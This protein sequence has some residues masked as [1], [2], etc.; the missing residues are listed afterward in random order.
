MCISPI[1]ILNKNYRSDSHRL[2]AGDI[3]N[4]KDTTSQ[5]ILVPCGHCPD[6]VRARQ[7]AI[8]QRTTL[9]SLG[10]HMFFAT[11]TYNNEHLP[12]AQNPF[13]PEESYAYADI[14]HLQ[15][16]M[17][18]LRNHGYVFRYL[19]CSERGTKRGR[20]HFHVLFFFDKNLY[21]DPYSLERRLFNDVLKLWAKNVGTRKD[22]KYIPLCTYTV[23]RNGR[24]NYD[25]HYCVPSPVNGYD[26]VAFYVS[27]Y[28][29]KFA[30]SD[31]KLK[32][33]IWNSLHESDVVFPEDGC[34]AL[35]FW[36]KIRCRYLSSISFGL[37]NYDK[38]DNDAF[39]AECILRKVR[40]MIDRSLATQPDK[41]PVF[42]RGDGKSFPLCKYLRDKFLT[43]N[44][45]F[46]SYFANVSN[47]VDNFQVHDEPDFNK[48]D[49]TIME[50]KCKVDLVNKKESP[51]DYEPCD[52]HNLPF[53]DYEEEERLSAGLPFNPAAGITP[54]TDFEFCLPPVDVVD[55]EKLLDSLFDFSSEESR[56][57]CRFFGVTDFD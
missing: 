42:Y 31:Y 43:V 32:Q 48:I 50:H 25:L 16:L 7:N 22:P 15:L 38:D 2:P 4:F 21:P 36:K 17:K 9:E 20:P 11:L 46:T 55:S 27:K 10:S 34:S 23:G 44:D 47:F 35:D 26:D 6:C 33:R 49:K 57:C 30:D 41:G 51:M 54:N 5:Y 28:M 56:D 3:R 29:F 13:R 14:T 52:L 53:Y 24:R 39:C 12:V 1:R 40:S 45:A 8:I 37:G 18:R 19:A